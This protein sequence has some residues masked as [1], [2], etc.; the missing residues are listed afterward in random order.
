VLEGEHGSSSRALFSFLTGVDIRRDAVSHWSHPRDDDDLSRC[1]WLARDV[2]EVGESMARANR[3]SSLWAGIVAHW[4]QLAA[5]IEPFGLQ[6]E[7]AARE[8]CYA[9]LDRLLREA[10]AGRPEERAAEHSGDRS[11]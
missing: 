10:I 2:P 8:R 6:P 5:F 3:M 11:A 7:R 4:Q 9:L 1:V